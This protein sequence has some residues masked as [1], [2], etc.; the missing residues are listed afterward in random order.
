MASLSE[1]SRIRGDAE[2]RYP[3]AITEPKGCRIREGDGGVTG[4]REKDEGGGN[5]EGNNQRKIFKK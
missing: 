5:R 2:V 4:G 1:L 3:N